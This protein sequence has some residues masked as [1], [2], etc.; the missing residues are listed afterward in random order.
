MNVKKIILIISLVIAILAFAAA[1]LFCYVL[2]YPFSPAKDAEDVDIYVRWGASFGQVANDLAEKGVV[3]SIEQFKFTA[4]LYD[5]TQK[6]RVGKFSLKRGMSNYAALNVLLTGPQS[7]ISVTL[8]N[9]YDSRRF[10]H[11]IERRLE[12]DSAKIV[13]LVADSVFVHELGINASSLEGFLYP[14]TYSFTFGSGAKQVLR[15]LVHQFK[16]TAPDSIFRS[17]AT[18]NWSVVNVLTLA[19]IIEGEAMV[20]SEMP[21]ISSVYHNRLHTGMPL[22]ADPT[23]QYIIPDGPRRLLRR[24]LKI[25]SPYNT[26]LYKGLPPGPINNPG[27][28]AIRAALHPAETNYL[29]FVAN[30]DGT[31]SFSRTFN[32]H[33]QAKRKFDK[34]RRQVDLEKKKKEL[35][36]RRNETVPN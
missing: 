2:Y 26:Y 16:K 18:H 24:D 17:A 7:Y 29:Y 34:I 27:I 9:G 28:N 3:R 25:D 20:D 14:E 10:A 19:S 32:E 23:I 35:N 13:A 6:L 8:P 4:R 22:Q 33:L 36:G 12:I 11:I 31:H 1:G 15:I 21:M 30:G 5:K